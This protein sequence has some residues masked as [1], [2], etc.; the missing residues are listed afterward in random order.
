MAIKSN[1]PINLFMVNTVKSEYP[2]KEGNS[3][4][5]GELL[6]FYMENEIT[7]VTNKIT[8]DEPANAIAI[9][10]GNSLERIPCYIL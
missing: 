8:A 1:S 10:S 7:Y 3:I 5:D 4:S 9:K 6:Y 2:I